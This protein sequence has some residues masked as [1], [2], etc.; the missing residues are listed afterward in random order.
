MVQILKTVSRG[1]LVEDLQRA[2]NAT[3]RPSP[4]L[5]PDGAFGLRTD[6][7]VKTFQR[8]EWLVAD[9][10][11]GPCT[12]NALYGHEAYP[13]ETGVQKLRNWGQITVSSNILDSWSTHFRRLYLSVCQPPYSFFKIIPARKLG[14]DHSCC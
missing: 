1:P 8:R 7:A 12:H 11:V 3:L 9:G 10:D 2:L 4:N 14:S 5:R 6:Q 13:P